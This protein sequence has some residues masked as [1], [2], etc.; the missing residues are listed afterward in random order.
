MRRLSGIIQVGPK[1][2]EK[3]PYKKESRRENTDRRE[4]DN[5]KVEAE[6]AIMSP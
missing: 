4:E 2:L 3:H 6:I 1:C 5:A